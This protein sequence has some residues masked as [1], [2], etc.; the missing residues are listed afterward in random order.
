VRF[1]HL[2]ARGGGLEKA[3]GDFNLV[4]VEAPGLFDA[5]LGGINALGGSREKWACYSEKNLL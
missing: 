5:Q 4:K 1:V 3:L 2:Q